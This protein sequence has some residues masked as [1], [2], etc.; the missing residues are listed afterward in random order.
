ME[1]ACVADFEV[2]I[3]LLCTARDFSKLKRSC[4]TASGFPF[5][6]NSLTIFFLPQI[7]ICH[8]QSEG[9]QF[10]VEKLDSVT[11]VVEGLLSLFCFL[12]YGSFQLLY[13]E[14]V[15]LDEGGVVGVVLEFLI[16]IE[17]LFGSAA[18][19]VA[20][21]LGSCIAVVAAEVDSNAGAHRK[22]QTQCTTFFTFIPFC[23]SFE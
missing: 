8:L 1:V 20:A 21:V 5:G 13:F 10:H 22:S 4:K 12:R 16:D 19:F 11:V 9:L 15:F 18:H 7:F 2:F 6:L 17:N 3:K 23:F 14:V